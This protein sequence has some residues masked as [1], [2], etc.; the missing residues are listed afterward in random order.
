MIVGTVR[1]LGGYISIK[2]VEIRDMF[3]VRIGYLRERGRYWVRRSE[4]RRRKAD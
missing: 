1:I 2:E 4:I 3:S